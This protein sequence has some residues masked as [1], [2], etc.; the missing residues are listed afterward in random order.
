MIYF[1]PQTDGENNRIIGKISRCPT[2]IS[3]ERIIL[4]KLDNVEKLPK[5]PTLPKPGPTLLIT[6][7]TD[8]NVVSKSNPFIDINN[9]DMQKINMHD[10]KNTAVPLMLSSSKKLP[11]IFIIFTERG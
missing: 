5:G 9:T 6:V 2:N 10:M 4:E 8:E 11:S 3:N 7:K 1:L